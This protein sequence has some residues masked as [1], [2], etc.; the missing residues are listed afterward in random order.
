M[1]EPKYYDA[2]AFARVKKEPPLENWCLALFSHH[3]KCDIIVNNIYDSFNS[4]ILEARDSPIISMLETIRKILMNRM[5]DR[6]TWM[7]K[8]HEPMG[9]AIRQIIEDTMKISRQWKP[10]SN[11]KGGYQISSD[12][13]YYADSCYNRNLFMQIYDNVLQPTNGKDLWPLSDEMDLDPPIPCMQAGRPKKAKKERRT[14]AGGGGAKK[15]AAGGGG[16]KEAAASGAGTGKPVARAGKTCNGGTNTGIAGAEEPTIGSDAN[17]DGNDA[18][19]EKNNGNV[20]AGC[21]KGKTS[22]PRRRE[23]PVHAPQPLVTQN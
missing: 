10:L 6:S 8:C 18:D 9:P 7:R 15:V 20:L 17:G 3:T 22:Q 16:V 2:D 4:H 12:P 5:E 21:K 14:T 23:I 11:G 13:Y 19:C 1:R